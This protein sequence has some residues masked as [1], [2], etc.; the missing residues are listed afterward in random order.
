MQI[1][2]EVKEG[3]CRPHLEQLEHEGAYEVW[4]QVVAAA[5]DQLV[6]VH[7]HELKDQ[8]QAPGGLVT[9][10]EACKVSTCLCRA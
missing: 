7:V 5:A 4:S 3:Q 8:R 1:C 10:Q 2:T 6:D 9:A